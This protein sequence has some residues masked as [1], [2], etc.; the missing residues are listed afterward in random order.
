MGLK[1]N[2]NI[3]EIR[4]FSQMIYLFEHFGFVYWVLENCL[5]EMQ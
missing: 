5:R 4:F 1:I 2:A 3:A